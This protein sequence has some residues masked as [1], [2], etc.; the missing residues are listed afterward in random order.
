MVDITGGTGA[1]GPTGDTGGTGATANPQP[2]T[3]AQARDKLLERDLNEVYLLL[4][5]VSGRPERRL[6]ELTMPDPTKDDGTIWK[7]GEIVRQIALIRYPP[8]KPATEEDEAQQAAVLLMA[9][10]ALS[11]L[12]SPAR[13]A[14]I[15]YTAMYVEAEAQPGPILQFGRWVSALWGHQA[16]QA[17][18]PEDHTG[19]LA[20]LARGPSRITR[21]TWRGSAFFADGSSG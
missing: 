20:D 9:K 13:G 19:S 4:D 5:F 14:T 15:A 8:K 21:N 2:A 17:E 12:A 10:D 7:S 3:S 6:G 11:H 1:T 16:P 18:S